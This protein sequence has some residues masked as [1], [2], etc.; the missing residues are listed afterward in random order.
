MIEE[1]VFWLA[2]RPSLAPLFELVSWPRAPVS[3]V[4]TANMFP[5]HFRCSYCYCCCGDAAAAA[6]VV[7]VADLMLTMDSWCSN[8]ATFS[9]ELAPMAADERVEA[10][11]ATPDAD[12]VGGVNRCCGGAA[13]VVSNCA[14]AAAAAAVVAADDVAVVD[15]E[16]R[17]DVDER[18]RAAAIADSTDELWHSWRIS[19][20]CPTISA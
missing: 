5:R 11:A 1:L 7:A 16:Q 10:A 15:V 9:S 14:A 17:P 12:S 8:C 4:C 3:F 19:T 2:M 18:A 13:M 6:A 20:S